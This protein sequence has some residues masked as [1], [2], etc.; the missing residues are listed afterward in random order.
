MQPEEFYTSRLICFPNFAYL[1][2]SSDFLISSLG[3]EVSDH[4]AL[5]GDD[6]SQLNLQLLHSPLTFPLFPSQFTN[7]L[8]VPL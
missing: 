6:N 5:G 8:L 4:P 1:L 2:V 3:D 7:F